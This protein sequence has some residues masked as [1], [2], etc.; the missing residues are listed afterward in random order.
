MFWCNKTNLRSHLL[1][2]SLQF[3]FVW[4]NRL[5]LS[6]LEVMYEQEKREKPFRHHLPLMIFDHSHRIPQATH[7]LWLCCQD[8][9]SRGSISFNYSHFS[10]IYTSVAR[11][12]LCKKK[13]SLYLRIYK[14]NVF[15]FSQSYTK[16]S[17][18]T[19]LSRAT[20]SHLV[21][22]CIK[23]WHQPVLIVSRPGKG[24]VFILFSVS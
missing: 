17:V 16:S 22:C 12:F 20:T 1:H 15:L 4:T 9:M 23:P 10:S 6:G 3:P 24:W 7:L 11:S 18:F 5:F 13:N 2:I 8:V 21:C 19:N 14:E